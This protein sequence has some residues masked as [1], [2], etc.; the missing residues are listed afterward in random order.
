VEASSHHIE[1]AAFKNAL[2]GA[3]EEESTPITRKSGW[4]GR[5]KKGHWVK[6]MQKMVW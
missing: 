5:K 1:R 4:K 3:G 6:N 2:E